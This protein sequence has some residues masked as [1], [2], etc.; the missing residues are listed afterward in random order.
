[1]RRWMVW[2]VVLMMIVPYGL[3]GPGNRTSAAGQTIVEEGEAPIEAYTN[4]WNVIPAWT[5]APVI[6]GELDE[7]A[8][9]GAAPLDDFRTAYYNEPAT[10]GIAY[11]VAYDETNLYIGGTF[12]EEERDVLE[13]I[14]IVISPQTA[15][16]L[17]YVAS[18]PVTPSGRTFT[19]GWNQTLDGV[20]PQ[21]VKISAFSHETSLAGGVFTVE[22]AIPLSAFGSAVV[23]P[24]AEWRMNIIHLH[25]LNT[26]PLSSWV[27]IRTSSFWDTSGAVKVPAN[28]VDEGRLGSVFFERTTQGVAWTLL[29]PELHYTGFATKRL[30]FDGT[31]LEPDD[32]VFELKWIDPLGNVT[33]LDDVQAAWEGSLS[34]LTFSHPGPLRDGMYQLQILA[35]EDDPA[36]CRFAL[37]TFDRD[38]LIDAGIQDAEQASPAGDVVPV[39]P[40]P[41]SAAVENILELIP[42]RVGFRFAGLPEMPELNP[43]GLYTLSADG[44]SMVAPK[45]GTAY[46]NAQYPETG[47][48]TAVNRKGETL[49]YPYYEDAEGKRYFLS[50]HLWYLQK[51]YTLNQTNAIA[52]TDPLGAARLLYRFAQVYEGYV[53]TTDY[54]WYNYP[55]NITSGPPFNYWG[56]MWNRWS[57]SDLNSLRPL[58][59]AYMEVKKTDALQVLSQ[60]VGEDVEKKL[61]EQV[62]MPSV[63]YALSYPTTLGNM[64]YTQWLGLIDAG[65][66]IGQPDYIHNVVE[67]MREYVDRRYRSDGFWYEVAPSYHVQSTDGLNLAIGQLQGY[68]DPTGYVSPRSGL[69][70]DNLD[71]YNDF[72]IIGKAKEIP[73]LL[74]FPNGQLLPV[75]DSW[76]SDKA[77]APRSDVGSMLLPDAG[78]GRLSGGTGADRTQL[79]LEFT[80]KTGHTHYDPLN[81]NLYAQGQELL[82]DLGYTYT[83]YRYFTLSTLGHNT[84][85][86]NGKNMTTAGA[87]KD[88]GA[89]EAFAS[90]GAFQ[91]MRA[92]EENAYAETEMYSREP[93]FVPFAGGNGG[94][95]YVLDLFRVKGGSRHE[96]TLQ[97]DANLDAEFETDLPLESYGPYL[98]PPGTEVHE[99]ESFNESGTAA[100]NYP[101]YIYV[102]DVQKAELSGDKYEVTLET[103]DNGA[104]K[105]K[106]KITGLLEEGNNEL[107]LGRSPSIRSTRLFGKSKD[108]NDEAVQYDMPKLVLRREAANL[109]STFV[110]A[111]EPYTGAAGSKIDSI[112]RL[113]P[114]QSPEGAVAV[115]VTYG[116]VTDY[117]LSSPEHPDQ[118]LVVGD[119]TM[120]GEMGFIRVEDGVVQNMYLVGGTEL[121]KGSKEISAQG[122]VTGTITGTKRKAN[123][124]PYDAIVTSTPIDPEIAAFL[125][126]NYVIVTHPDGSTNGYKIGDIRSVAGQTAIV[127]AEYDPGFEL[128]ADGTSQMMFYPAKSW[129]GAHTFK[130]A[131]VEALDRNPLQAVTLEAPQRDLPKGET[132]PLAVYGVNRDGSPAVL[133]AG[134][135]VFTSSDPA[136]LVVDASG[137]VTAVGDGTAT[138]SVEVTLNGVTKTASVVMSSQSRSLQTYNIVDLNIAEQTVPTLYVTDT[139][140]VQLEAN[141]AGQGISFDFEVAEDA[142]YAIGI[143]PFKAGSYGKYKISVDGTELMI[144]DFYSSIGGASTAF[145]TIGTMPLTAGTHRIALVGDG[146]NASSSNYKFGLIQ[147][148]MKES[149]PDAPALQAAAGPI[150]PGQAF[151][152]TFADS[153]AWRSEI[154]GVTVDGVPLASGQYT[155]SPGSIAFAADALPAGE[156]AAWIVVQATGYRH[157]AA[158]QRIASAAALSGLAVGPGTLSPPFAPEMRDYAVLVDEDVSALTVTAQTYR[159]DALI[160]VGGQ[161]YGSAATIPLALQPGA[162]PLSLAV[163][164][165]DGSSAI[166]T[167]TAYR[168]VRE[169]EPIGTVAGAVYGAGGAPVAGAVLRFVGQAEVAATTDEDGRFAIAEV[170]NGS[171]QLAVTK[172][173]YLDGLSNVFEVTTRQTTSVDVTLQRSPVPVLSGVTYGAAAI[174][175]PVSATMSRDG[176]LYL[177]P[178]GTA[179]TQTAIEAASVVTVGGAVYGTRATA[180]AGV[181]AALDTT[182]FASG[183]YVAYAID[184]AGNVSAGSERIA[185][186]PRSLAAIDNTSPFVMYSGSGTTTTS[187]SLLYGGS[188]WIGTEKGATARAPFYG[189]RGQVLATRASNGGLADIYVDGVYR[190]TY[191]FVKRGTAQYQSVVFDTGLL[192]LG[193]HTVDIVSKGEIGANSQNNWIRFDALLVNGY[194][195]IGTVTGTVY[196]EEGAPLTGA[197]VRLVGQ[198][199]VAAAT[200]DGDGRYTIAN[201]PGGSWQLAAT[202][203]DYV[204]GLSD[205]FAVENGQTT[206]VDVTLQ[207]SPVPVLSGVTYGAAAIGDPVSATMSRDGVL[208]LVPA[209]TAATRTAIEAASVVTV[210]GAVYGARATAASGVAAVLDTTDFASGLYVVYA[211]DGAGNVSAAS[212]RIAIIPRSLAAIDNTSPFVMYS[213]SGTTTTSASLYGGSEWI[214]TAKGATAR[215]PFYGTKAKVL[216]TLAPN[217]GLGDIYVDGIYRTTYDFMRRGTAQI[218]YVVFDT[219]VLPLGAHTIEIRATGE[220]NPNSQ[221][222]WVRFDALLAS[223]F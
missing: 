210:G 2:T 126:G 23:S 118:P 191:D 186:I 39:T 89:I 219:G 153:A 115:K 97:G 212:E 96:Y 198:A 131:N 184:G 75:Q 98:L 211:T 133:S 180:V 13:R 203:L 102:N 140:T 138:V 90:V 76:A 5:A 110:T 109:N 121:K 106:L 182:D 152:M 199:E 145:E 193:A 29:E 125:K 36:D 213:G 163:A 31:S 161:T 103:S 177:V 4:K 37:L 142:A 44:K 9:S 8:W 200:T 104:D 83:K 157:A 130:I 54:N 116:D 60:E 56:G 93:W 221:N 38:S 49:E 216:G 201:A 14:E 33:T 92:S 35:C 64:D 34:V 172:L 73:N 52:K 154:S 167:V 148:E 205:V 175:D 95:G 174:G 24:G 84:V 30:S 55:I 218:Q 101:A 119:I 185:I 47:T 65:K 58:L 99:A 170:P 15:G 195:S 217:G 135:T 128:K 112:K 156:G 87:G 77:K 69:H 74:S 158:E 91:A 46:P 61:V 134:E 82:P 11:K 173:D 16:G 214:G 127:L 63:D 179:A 160:T 28:V 139:N 67:W 19:T 192:P 50:A 183:L 22:A 169:F 204:D 79:Y 10:G 149:L 222:I 122:S 209:G 151:A 114:S 178:T 25:H 105:A 48:V 164:A 27:P 159:P 1:M 6:D 187:A 17:H 165:S 57:V 223:G 123:G 208:H 144:Y 40:A 166:Y 45:T 207:R 113:E 94:E 132:V 100:G 202:K 32:T 71:M 141:A 181:A 196:G 194:E 117:L 136:V 188:E 143:K 70:F 124:D 150:Y 68:S 190:T 220:K 72:P 26:K 51:A 80:P 120:R 129:T 162:N 41:A 78:I 42:D 3:L 62:V 171:W 137:N 168:D 21:R 7:A 189:T 53:P 86:V 18:I 146:K 43:D 108:T 111:L 176:V 81:L 59:Q 66:A 197:V 107:Y 85:V 88:G 206:S 147:L 215:V 155:V 12:D 20:D